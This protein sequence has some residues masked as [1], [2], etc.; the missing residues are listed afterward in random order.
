MRG[1]SRVVSLLATVVASLAVSVMLDLH[2]AGA[3]T[4]TTS[5]WQTRLNS[6][7]ITSFSD[8]SCPT[9]LVC[10]AVG[11]GDENRAAIF[12][13]S[14]GG[15]SWARQFIASDTA[16]S[17]EVTCPTTKFCLVTVN[18]PYST[19]I[20]ST[21]DAGA[22]WHFAAGGGRDDFYASNLN[23]VS[24]TACY[25]IQLIGTS[26]M[27]SSD[28]GVTWSSPVASLPNIAAVDAVSCPSAATCFIIGSNSANTSLVIDKSTKS[29]SKIAT[30]RTLTGTTFGTIS[31][32]TT[33]RC[34]AA[35]DLAQGGRTFWTSDGGGTWSPHALPA[36]TTPGGTMR[37]ESASTCVVAAS[38]PDFNELVAATTTDA[39]GTW[40]VTAVAPSTAPWASPGGLAC[41][42]LGE[43][44][45]VGFGTAGSSIFGQHATNQPWVDLSVP[46]GPRP[47]AAVACP[48]ASL[49]VAVGTGVAMRSVDGG[50]SWKMAK[51]V[52][53][54]NAIL[55]A[56]ACPTPT[57]C[58]AVGYVNPYL[59]DQTGVMFRSA[60]AGTTW[61]AVKIPVGETSLWSVACPTQKVCI[62]T[63]AAA[64]VLRSSDGGTNWTRVP[65]PAG[66]G[67]YSVACGS[68]SHC[69]G[70]GQGPSSGAVLV[71]S[72][73]GLS[74]TTIPSGASLGEYLTSVSC[75]SVTK[76]VAAGGAQPNSP[77]NELAGI[78]G[79]VD[80][81]QHWSQLATTDGFN[82]TNAVACSGLVCEEIL[83]LGQ[84]YGP[85]IS[86]LETSVDGGSHWS[87][88]SIPSQPI[89]NGMTV[90][91][92]G[93]WVLVGGNVLN[94]AAVLTN[95]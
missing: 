24:P 58:V 41:P 4:S 29:G 66:F 81:G 20:Y 5:A 51:V 92:S 2:P 6:L 57:R 7:G 77:G 40:K 31:C 16:S 59:P 10:T 55:S 35:V 46:S 42:A 8:I 73:A 52:P 82:D 26:L 34:A 3:A 54:A 12:R 30:V 37:C 62:A 28:G 32:T 78:Y 76:C 21:S 74:W 48:T 63:T 83:T 45:A 72:N 38:Y 25:G 15:A 93:R 44:F 88:T 50:I 33:S 87:A 84:N 60:D 64:H 11:G 65:I 18:N 9:R 86:V 19:D 53:D 17:G 13:S 39:G 79:T 36:G 56:I 68:T 90:T 1:T 94:G 69:I 80:G 14:D 75:V 89:M 70:A 95:P 91:P 49:C 61:S 47:L 22:T 67:L 71:T 43:C 27:F 85:P 23:C